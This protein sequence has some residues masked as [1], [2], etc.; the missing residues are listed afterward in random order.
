MEITAQALDGVHGLPAVGVRVRLERSVDGHWALL[1]DSEVGEDGRVD[2]WHGRPLQRGLYRISFDSDYY[3]GSMGLTAAYPEV[4]LVF[5]A[6]GDADSCRIQVV[7]A[8]YT[9]STH[10]SFRR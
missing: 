6:R 4:S 9:C 2:K 8:P 5:R 10:L 3:F 7:L 1:A